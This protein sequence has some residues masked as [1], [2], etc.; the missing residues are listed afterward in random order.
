M[1]HGY[2]KL[3]ALYMTVS[4]WDYKIMKKF[5]RNYAIISYLKTS[6]LFVKAFKSYLLNIQKKEYIK[7]QQPSFPKTLN[8]TDKSHTLY[9]SS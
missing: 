9:N 3:R 7:I 2:T 4:W 6:E 8:Q 5:K 1:L